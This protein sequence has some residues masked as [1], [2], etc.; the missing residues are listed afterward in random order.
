MP[1]HAARRALSF[2]TGPSSWLQ[3]SGRCE[4]FKVRRS[5]SPPGTHGSSADQNDSCAFTLPQLHTCLKPRPIATCVLPHSRLCTYT[6]ADERHAHASLARN[7][8]Y[9]ALRQARLARGSLGI[10]GTLLGSSMG[11]S[12]ACARGNPSRCSIFGS[13]AGASA[14]G[15]GRAFGGALIQAIESAHVFTP[16]MSGPMSAFL[17]GC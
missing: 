13:A 10:L 7:I 16:S 1:S 4:P 2:T 9:D 6:L 8:L 15:A 11:S 12:A 5:S 14:V 3:G 17:L